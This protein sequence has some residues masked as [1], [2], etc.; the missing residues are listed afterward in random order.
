MVSSGLPQHQPQQQA[1][2]TQDV[3][4]GAVH[5]HKPAGRGLSEE[6]GKLAAAKEN[7]RRYKTVLM[8]QME[9]CEGPTL[10]KWLDAPCRRAAQSAHSNRFVRGR[11]GE[12]LELVFAKQLM[13]GIRE[14]HAADMVHR[15]VKPQN[16]FVTHD[17]V[18]KIGDFGLSRCAADRQEGGEKGVVG[19]PGYCAPEGGSGAAAPADIFSA[20]LVILELL[21]PPLGTDMERVRV[22]EDLRER[23]LLP[24][25]VEEE[26]PEH[27]TL[28]KHMARHTPQDR[29]SAEE[30]HAVLKR[31]GTGGPLSPILEAAAEPP[32][33]GC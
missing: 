14:I 25:H 27:A 23:Q 24:A 18:L 28:L 22:L 1:I 12:A 5:P 20:A 16:L 29:P 13:K 10:R 30:V 19:T 7:P 15:D 9:L 31:L 11:K 8:I 21:C 6:M 17:D 2:R 33:T 32:V 3:E 4:E 26:L